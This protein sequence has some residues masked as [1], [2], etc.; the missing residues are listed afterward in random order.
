MTTSPN[1]CQHCG[2][3]EREHMQRW[4][5]GAGWHQWTRPTQQQIK[6]RMLARRATRKAR[7]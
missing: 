2:V 4:K 7:S 3:D 1:G 5:H 6:T